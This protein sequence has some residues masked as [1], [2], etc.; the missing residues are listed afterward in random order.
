MKKQPEREIIEFKC[1]KCG[2]GQSYKN[3]TKYSEGGEC[4]SCGAL[5]FHKQINKYNLASSPLNIKCPYCGSTNT[6]KISKTS[7]VGRI[8]VFGVFA[9][10]KVSKQWHCNKCKSDF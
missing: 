9:I 4:V 10:D 7:K 8:A 2:C 1:P 3:I 5:T 6:K